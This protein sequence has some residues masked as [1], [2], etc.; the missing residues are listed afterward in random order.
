MT[1]TAAAVTVEGGMVVGGPDTISP[2]KICD[3]WMQWKKIT[4][5]KIKSSSFLFS[6]F[7]TNKMVFKH[8]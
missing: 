7:I 8:I 5:S 1:E 2:I 3:I 6:L 4:Q